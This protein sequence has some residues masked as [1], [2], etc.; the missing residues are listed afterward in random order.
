[1]TAIAA[2]APISM[3]TAQVRRVA[4]W[5]AA[6]VLIF[7]IGLVVPWSVELGS[8][9]I[10][11]PR[12]VLLVVT[13]PCLLKWARGE[14][15]QRN[16]V[17][18]LLLALCAWICLSLAVV[19]GWTSGLESG[20]MVAVETA[21]SYFLARCYVRTA[22]DFL[23]VVRVLF[24]C[25]IALLPL[26]IVE[27]LTGTNLPMDFFGSILP[28]VAVSY[29]G[30][31]WGLK[32]VQS[33]YEHP[34]LFGVCTGSMLAL[35]YLVLGDTH[36]IWRRGLGTVLVAATAFL[37]ISSG[38]L[39][40]MAFQVALIGWAKT[41][42]RIPHNWMLLGGIFAATFLAIELGST[43]S[44][45]QFYIAR[46]SLD[47][48]TAWLRLLI[49]EFGSASVLAHPLF[50][51]GFGQWMRPVW[52]SDS[53]DMFWMTVAIRHGIPGGF[54]MMSL[55]AV[56][57]AITT[58]A[59]QPDRRVAL[60]RVAYL[61]VIASFFLVGWTV[62]FW[63]AAYLL[64]LFLLGAGGWLASVTSV[65][66]VEHIRLRGGAAIAHLVRAEKL[67]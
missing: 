2:R 4:Q 28:T 41:T 1:M 36:S 25:V 29:D 15:G 23:A 13:V 26:A 34:I 62:H 65:P 60:Y 14:A 52:M 3:R 19:E 54:L 53:I 18:F 56:T 33:V 30:L 59:H 38:A 11:L 45:P 58:S 66:V 49:W 43:Q 47:R 20:G 7:L 16:L 21:G 8:F 40:M 50:G 57:L 51:I 61:I 27:A 63:G 55:P 31:R 35:V 5:P 22:D 24:F 39:A 46:F 64:F 9:G 67:S 12:L 10:T 48:E 17:D 6:P 44:V 42:S 32:R 37:S